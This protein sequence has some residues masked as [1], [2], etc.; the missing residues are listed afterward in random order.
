MKGGLLLMAVM[1]CNFAFAQRTV[2]GTVTDAQTG[3]PLIGANILVVGTSGGTITDFD[4]NY[5]VNVPEGASSLEFSYT[6][7]ASQVVE[8]GS[9]SKIDMQLSAGEVLDEVVVIGYG[10]VR[11]E[12][13]TGAVQQLTSKDF[14][15]GVIVSP[16]QM[17]QGRAA[18]VQITPASGEPGAGANIRIRGT[19]S[20]RAGNNPLIVLDGVPLDGRDVSAGADVGAGRNASRNPL[21]FINPNDIASI[22]VL[23]DASATAI[24]GSRGA[25]GVIIIET[26][27]GSRQRPELSFSALGTMSTMPAERKYDLLSAD[28]FRTENG[29]PNLDFGDNVDAFDEITRTAYTQNY[30]LAYG[31]ASENGRYRFSLGV[32]DQE[33]IIKN[34]GLKKYTGTMNISQNFWNDRLKISGLLIGSFLEDEAA[35]LAGTVGAEGDLMISALRWN[36]TRPFTDDR[37]EFIQPS[38]NER[39]PLAF[40][41]LFDDFTETS[42]IF[43]NI[44]ATF[45]IV[46][47]LDYKYN[48]GIDRSESNRR[49]AISRAFVANFAQNS[50][51]ANIEGI[52]QY[53][54]LHEHTLSYNKELGASNRINA[55]VG[56][57]YQEFQRRGN[58]IRA[59]NFLI[60]DQGL[61]TNNLNYASGFPVENNSS[62]FDPN[63][64]L[65]SFFG[66]AVFSL[67]DRFLIT[68]TVRADG[69]SRFGEGNRY[70]V[71][72][73]A[74]FA[75]QMHK[76]AFIPDAFDNLKLRLSWGITG[77]QEFPSGSAQTQFQ[78]LDNGAGI[79]RTIVGNPDLKWEETTQYNAGFDFAFMDYRLTGS[80]DWYLKET[81]DLLFRIQ[82]AGQAP[83]VFIWR[84]LDDITVEN[85]GVDFNLDYVLVSNDNMLWDVGINASIFNNTV[86]NV[87][88]IFPNGIITGEINGQGLSNQRAQL[89]FDDQPLYAFYLAQFTGFDSEGNATF[90]DLNN[91]GQNTASGIVGPGEG[92]RT[93][94]GDPN[95]DFTLG[96]RTGLSVG[97]FDASL[98]AYGNF[99]QQV[100]DNT[101]LALF[102]QAALEGGANVDERVLGS[103]QNGSDSPVPS[104]LFLEDADFFR[105]ANL[106]LGYNFNIGEST[107]I[108][109]ARVFVT[110]QNL[111]V[112]T[113]YNGFDPEINVDKAIDEVPSFGIDYS[114]Y[115]RARSFS[116]G[117]NFNF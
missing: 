28:Q 58:N 32:L 3:E 9:Q 83:D 39:N 52:Q 98:Y 33:G 31:G 1:L 87:S 116:L 73:S 49:I 86:R 102:N 30:N 110:G 112:F 94:V 78:P 80:V 42:R 56:Y 67:S 62:F 95:P 76:E 16:E 70:G 36:P 50:G 29:N 111:F 68:G 45:N 17:I 54:Q 43:G 7:Y 79:T 13:A 53:S 99:G 19:S 23:K 11:K 85:M 61:Y 108:R 96:F 8:I 37:G 47:G 25:N 93:F 72:P 117:V 90:A 103:G 63:D 92:D 26:K 44:S 100:F 97:N 55:V 69:S 77:N 66:R 71:F 4:G 22:N 51:L 35:P 10:T 60:D 82:A 5:S 84:N 64:E 41:D 24:Y 101:A 106:T 12:D 109:S 15:K 104:T 57:S 81:V 14:N 115:P 38:D 20:I 2:T 59:T 27:Q 46:E 40:L 91:D 21:N 88:G 74:A 6:G 34:T 105:I 18:G 65:Q 48:F 114:A 113:G 89:I 107:W 75:W